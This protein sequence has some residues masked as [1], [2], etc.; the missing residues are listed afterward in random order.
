MQLDRP[1]FEIT[2]EMID[3]GVSIVQR[4]ED[5]YGGDIQ[6][7][8]AYADLVTAILCSFGSQSGLACH[9]K[10]GRWSGLLSHIPVSEMP[11]GVADLGFVRAHRILN[12]E[13]GLISDLFGV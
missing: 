10:P 12:S 11:Y 5:Q 13:R 4:W 2:P 9:A 3:V 1:A 7:Q 8:A 6:S